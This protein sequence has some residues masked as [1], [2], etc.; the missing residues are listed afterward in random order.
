MT[1]MLFADHFI[2]IGRQAGDSSFQRNPMRF[3]HPFHIIYVNI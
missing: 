1:R 3:I 2:A